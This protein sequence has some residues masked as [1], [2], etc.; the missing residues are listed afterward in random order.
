MRK[1]RN[2]FPALCS[3]AASPSRNTA[4]LY[5]DDS[6]TAQGTPLPR[7]RKIKEIVNS[8]RN[9]KNKI[10]AMPADAAAIPANPKNAAT[11]ATIKK[12]TAQP[13]M[14]HLLPGLAAA[15]RAKIPA[16]RILNLMSIL[17]LNN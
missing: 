6:I 13:N 16:D 12:N 1:L 9:M 8:T 11:I 2:P 7:H 10:F 5:L 14:F 3:F 15:L 4:T 17:E